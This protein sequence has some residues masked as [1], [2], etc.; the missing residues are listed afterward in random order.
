MKNIIKLITILAVVS[1]TALAQ[2]RPAEIVT[3]PDGRRAMILEPNQS[4]PPFVET[5][6]TT[7]SELTEE[8]ETSGKSTPNTWEFTFGG[9]GETINNVEDSVFYLDISAATN[10]IKPLPNLWFGVVQG[11]AWEPKLA[12]ATDIYAEWS[13]HLWKELWVN[14]GYSGGVVYNSYDDTEEEDYSSYWRHGP[15]VTFQYYVG[16]NAFLYAGVNYDI[17]PKRE[18]GFR[19]SAGIGL[20]F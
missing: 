18:N 16:S 8:E 7:A 9:A 15:Q 10:P 20:A 6:P 5:G 12:G 11:F 19:Y 3:L 14:T 17:V 2:S 13:F 1:A 4:L